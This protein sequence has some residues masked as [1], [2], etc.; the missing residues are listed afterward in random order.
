MERLR[1]FETIFYPKSVAVIGASTETT[2][3]GTVFLDSLVQFGFKGK[4]YPVNPQ[5]KEILGLKAYPNV[6]DIPDPVDLVFITVPASA[7]PKVLEDCVTKN[8]RAVVILTAGFGETG[9]EEGRKL[10][11][12]IV[13]ISKEGNVRVVGPNCFGVYCPASGLTLL[14]GANFSKESG[15]VAFLSQSGGYAE[16]FCQEAKGWG[17]RFSKVVSYGNACDLNETN[18]IEYLAE[19]S[20]TRIIALYVEGVKDGQRFLQTVQKVNKRKPVIVWKGGL[21][22]G[23]G[24]A[25][26]SHTGALG[27]RK[28]IW[29][30][31]FRQTGAVRV[32]SLEELIDTVLIFQHFSSSCGRRVAVVGTGGGTG[33]AAADACERAGLLVPAFNAET[34]E[35]LRRLIPPIGA[36]IQNP[37]DLGN[38]WTSPPI[39]RRIIEA[40][41]SDP[42][43]DALIIV[44]WHLPLFYAR[45]E[46][47]WKFFQQIVEVPI[48]IS[49]RQ[50]KPVV[51]VLCATPTEVEMLEVEG[52]W[53]RIK[54]RYL[55]AGIPV[56]PT[57]ERTTKALANFVA[58]HKFQ[59]H[60]TDL[61]LSL[62][63]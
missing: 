52:E 32:N 36:S 42:Q 58:Y 43:I 15:N 7:V 10:E 14:P 21:S 12:E 44:M 48:T 53:R 41:S 39:Y 4:I 5:A 8:V 9:K 63:G 60:E 17:I 27:G 24:R 61:G 40:V 11:R 31:F 56:Y 57:V 35:Q 55:A 13:R 62:E 28:E 22:E 29:D 34:L 45:R 37:I 20:E 46:L 6:K 33:V 26:A 49:K 1:E 30:A 19:D 59:K 18:F 38:P 25:V 23:G 16:R 51:M 54:D 2:K 50:R 47:L 3:F